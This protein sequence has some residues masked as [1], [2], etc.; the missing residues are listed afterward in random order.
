M[1]SIFPL[2]SDHQSVAIALV[3]ERN[4]NNCYNEMKWFRTSRWGQSG[5]TWVMIIESFGQLL[6][7]T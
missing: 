3:E 5:V 6:H 2:S 7:G 4:P 1:A